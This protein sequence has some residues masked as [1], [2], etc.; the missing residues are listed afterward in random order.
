MDGLLG[1]LSWNSSELDVYSNEDLELFTDEKQFYQPEEPQVYTETTQRK[2]KQPHT[3]SRKNPPLV[4]AEEKFFDPQTTVYSPLLDLYAA[5]QH[6]HNVQQQQVQFQQQF[7]QQI[8]QQM[9]MQMRLHMQNGQVPA[10]GGK[11]KGEK[12]KSATKGSKVSQR[13]Q[14]LQVIESGLGDYS[15]DALTNSLGNDSMPEKPANTGRKPPALK[16]QKVAPSAVKKDKKS[17][18]VNSR[19]KASV[20]NDTSDD[21]EEDDDEEDD[22]IDDDENDDEDQLSTQGGSSARSITAAAKERRRYDDSGYYNNKLSSVFIK[23]LIILTY[24][25]AK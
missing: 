24:Q 7:Q 13:D 6:I 14:L 4:S 17:S 10:P 5:Q 23:K 22:D 19:Q 16:K 11:V 12:R 20:E 21:D 3:G 15:F 2:Q 18:I 9:Q 1:N 8:Q 25:R